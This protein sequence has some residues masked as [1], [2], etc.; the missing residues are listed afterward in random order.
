MG[1]GYAHELTILYDID[2]E[3]HKKD[4]MDKDNLTDEEKEELISKIDSKNATTLMECENN[5]VSF[6]NDG[7]YDSKFELNTTQLKE[8]PSKLNMLYGARGT[9]VEHTGERIFFRVTDIQN[10]HGRKKAFKNVDNVSDL[11]NTLYNKGYLGKYEY[12][13][14]GKNLYY[15]T[16]KCEDIL[17]EFKPNKSFEDYWK[18]FKKQAGL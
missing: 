13:F 9:S 6:I 8:M 10:I 4:I 12:Q 17:I 1:K 2:L 14:N 7:Q 5:A 15:L 11:L 18:S 16:P 3:E